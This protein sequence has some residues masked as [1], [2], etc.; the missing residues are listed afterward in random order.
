MI[1]PKPS[2]SF[3]LS[4]S[5]W[6]DS[7]SHISWPPHQRVHSKEARHLQVIDIA[8]SKRRFLSSVDHGEGYRGPNLVCWG[9]R[10]W[11][12]KVTRQRHRFSGPLGSWN[13]SVRLSAS[14]A[15]SS[16]PFGFCSLSDLLPCWCGSVAMRPILPVF[17]SLAAA[18]FTKKIIFFSF[19]FFS[20]WYGWDG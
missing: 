17:V 11:G 16:P 8:T 20:S 4:L 19:G 6:N 18:F 14:L 7:S 3:L 2:L 9:S 15:R 13:S 5:L 10:W 1:T 12:R